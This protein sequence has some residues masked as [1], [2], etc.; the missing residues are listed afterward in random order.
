MRMTTQ[1]SEMIK[2]TYLVIPLGL[3]CHE[4]VEKVI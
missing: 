4:V 1:L 3:E 2:I